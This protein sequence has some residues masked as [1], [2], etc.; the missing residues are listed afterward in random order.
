MDNSN[1]NDLTIFRTSQ[2]LWPGDLLHRLHAL[3]D[4]F[5]IK[6]AFSSETFSTIQ[7]G[8]LLSLSPR[9]AIL[10]FRDG[11]AFAG[12]RDRCPEHQILG[13]LRTGCADIAWMDTH[14]CGDR[15]AWRRGHRYV[16]VLLP[17][18][19]EGSGN[20][21]K[22]LTGHADLPVHTRTAVSDSRP[23][24]AADEEAGQ[25]LCQRGS[26]PPLLY[27]LACSVGRRASMDQYRHPR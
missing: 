22:L 15:K 21:G 9:T 19:Y 26:R 16:V 7:K 13:S 10:C 5:L 4:D 23:A 1:T 8:I 14:D 11:C 18:S 25:L 12:E 24:L 3:H 2:P 6:S 27:L 20:L 17:G